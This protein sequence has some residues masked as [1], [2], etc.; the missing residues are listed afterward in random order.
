[1]TLRS[2]RL[3][4]EPSP[5]PIQSP[6]NH[7]RS[8]AHRGS[9]ERHD[10]SLPIPIRDFGDLDLI[11]IVL[12]LP[13]TISTFRESRN[14]PSTDV[15]GSFFTSRLTLGSPSITLDPAIKL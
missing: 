5:Q 9:G 6:Q 2:A 10:A 11:I 13:K 15:N 4:P 3:W 7:E 14:C 8:H 1:M 12:S